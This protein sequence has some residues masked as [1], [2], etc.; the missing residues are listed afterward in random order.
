MPQ[1]LQVIRKERERKGERLQPLNFFFRIVCF[2]EAFEK[3]FWAN[4]LESI[5]FETYKLHYIPMMSKA[6]RTHSVVEFL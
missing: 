5:A 2:L 3:T 6:Y 4:E 1:N